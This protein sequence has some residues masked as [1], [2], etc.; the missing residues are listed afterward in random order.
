MY[1]EAMEDAGLEEIK[2]L[3]DGDGRLWR[4]VPKRRWQAKYTKKNLKSNKEVLLIYKYRSG[5][6]CNEA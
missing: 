2:I 4:T 6:N 3:K 1:R 5:T